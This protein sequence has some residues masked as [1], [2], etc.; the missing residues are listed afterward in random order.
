[1]KQ[2]KH[3]DDMHY[4]YPDCPDPRIHQIP[5]DPAS[6]WEMVNK[7]GTYN[8]QPTSDADHQYPSIH[9]GLPTQWKHLRQSKLE[10]FPDYV[11]K[12]KP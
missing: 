7:Y 1:M 11:Q 4:P 9:Q 8:I 6:A 5:G 3:V 12:N 2:E 10:L